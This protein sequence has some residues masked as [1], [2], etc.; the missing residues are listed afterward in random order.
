M[1]M[2][3]SMMGQNG[4][5]V[6]EPNNNNNNCNNDKV[7]YVKFPKNG[8][9]DVTFFVSTAIAQQNGGGHVD[10]IRES[11]EVNITEHVNLDRNRYGLVEAACQE[12]SESASSSFEESISGIGDD[13]DLYGDATSALTFGDLTNLLGMRKK[14]TSQWRGFIRSL[15]WRCKWIELQLV[16]FKS[17]AQKYDKEL[18][19]YNDRKQIEFGNF[20][21]EI[22]NSKSIPFP[23]TPQRN[24]V[25]GRKRRR[26]DEEKQNVAEYMSKH[27]LF[28][29]Y[30]NRKSPADGAFWTDHQFNPA[31]V[32]S[33]ELKS[34]NELN[35]DKEPL[36]NIKLMDRSNPMEQR[37]RKIWDLQS[38]V[39]TIKAG[40]EK[41]MN[42]NGG[43]GIIHADTTSLQNITENGGNGIINADTTSL[44]NITENGVNGIIHADTTSLQN[45]TDLPPEDRDR[46][47]ERCP[48]IVAQLLA[49]YSVRGGL[50]IPCSDICENGKTMSELTDQCL[51]VG[52]RVNNEDIFM[53][54]DHK[55]KEQIRSFQEV[56]VMK[57][58]DKCSLR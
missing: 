5:P 53:I 13:S 33:E 35:L 39:S 8:N 32:S 38:R 15:M 42:E 27:N 17:Q 31:L 7:N 40:L 2:E 3:D 54:Y 24:Q 9:D 20:G 4:N 19:Q 52:T 16:K 58:E 29:I 51:V 46:M 18:A 30:E 55:T 10:L 45:V 57:C 25:H 6:K 41:I 28:S 49:E 34:I 44:Q 50:S 21:P 47:T 48:A 12:T 14:V 23:F 11:S 43:N 56:E 26:R 37:L 36:Q 1:A 22:I